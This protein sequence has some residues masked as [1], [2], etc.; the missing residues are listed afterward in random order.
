MWIV[1]SL[2]FLKVEKTEKFKTFENY[3]YFVLK[4]KIMHA[5]I[6]SCLVCILK[7]SKVGILVPLK[8]TYLIKLYD[9]ALLC[10]L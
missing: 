3:M 9:W 4:D 10:P 1:T 2:V 8:K 5:F 6:F 7:F